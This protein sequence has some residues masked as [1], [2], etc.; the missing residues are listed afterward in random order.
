MHHLACGIVERVTFSAP[1]RRKN[2]PTLY[3]Q[4][5]GRKRPARRGVPVL[6]D[7]V[8]CAKIC[9]YIFGLPNIKY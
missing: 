5:M 6:D 3:L 7:F 8:F 1:A 4:H 2:I 9:C